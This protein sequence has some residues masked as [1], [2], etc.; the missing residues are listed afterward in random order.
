MPGPYIGIPKVLD[1]TTYYGQ[2]FSSP[3]KTKEPGILR[4][5]VLVRQKGLEPLTY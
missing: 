5:Q 1:V 2:P 4:F 3:E